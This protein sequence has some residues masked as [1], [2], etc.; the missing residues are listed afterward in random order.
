[1]IP[2]PKLVRQRDD[3]WRVFLDGGFVD[4]PFAP[5]PDVHEISVVTEAGPGGTASWAACTCHWAGPTHSTRATASVD[6]RNHLK[7]C[8]EAVL[9]DA[10]YDTEGII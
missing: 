3:H 4:V 5:P 7:S 8:L 9:M 1:M 6:G 10:L 2:T